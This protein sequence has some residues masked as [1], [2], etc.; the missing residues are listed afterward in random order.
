VS[1][2]EIAT[3]R[4]WTN[5][6]W[7]ESLQVVGAYRPDWM[8]GEWTKHL[9]ARIAIWA[10]LGLIVVLIDPILDLLFG[11][12]DLAAVS[13]LVLRRGPALFALVLLGATA[14]ALL[15]RYY[16]YRGWSQAQE[17]GLES[18]QMEI[19]T[20]G[21][22]PVGHPFVNGMHPFF[23][24]EE[25]SRVEFS[26]TRRKLQLDIRF[27]GSD[28]PLGVTLGSLQS[29]DLTASLATHERAMGS[30]LGQALERYAGMRQSGMIKGSGTASA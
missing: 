23:G 10:A 9:G 7:G 4:T 16:L 17:V 14:V 2:E 1:F 26:F 6:A 20:Q 21:I 18:G 22:Y 3:Q 8:T 5:P 11:R 27:R 25:V 24:W 15:E 19:F 29:E 13:G 30:P 28:H 12:L